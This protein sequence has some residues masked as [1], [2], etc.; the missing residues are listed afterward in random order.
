MQD[1]SH[2]LKGG[3][4]LALLYGLDRH[5]VDL[6]F[7]GAGA[8]SESIETYVCG[9]FEDAQVEMISFRRD[10]DT[11]KGQRYK[12]HYLNPE[13]HQDCLLKVELS[14]RTPPRSG[15]VHIVAGIR[16]YSLRALF[17]QK[18]RAANN[19]TKARDLF[20]LG[21]L[22]ETYG[23]E[24]STEQILRADDF[25]RDYERVADWYRLAFHE[26]RY[27]K[28]L[29][30]ADDRA[31]VLRIAVVEQLGRR[32]HSVQ[33]QAV[34]GDSAL[35]DMLASHRNWLESDGQKGSR[36]D[37]SDRSF[38][39][40]VLCNVN[41]ERAYL[42]RVN[43]SGADLRNANLRD[44]DL[45]DANMESTDLRGTDLSGAD[46]T[47]ASLDKCTLGPSTKGFVEAITDVVR[48]DRSRY[49]HHH[50]VS[51]QGEP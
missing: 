38:A 17:D 21:F 7:D 42:R 24:F 13:D 44:T 31:L 51:R 3:T 14:F 48:P 11:W 16:T 15:D 34:R 8:E 43:L 40:S 30:T 50:P 5:S 12:A 46:L 18:L 35:P 47:G 41:F 29:T 22:A 25:S 32:G 20:D 26:D 37:L 28:D 19:R 27:L 4:A 39:G 2:V 6:D 1:T 33:E 10:Y 36:A 45:R 49:I 9:G 23:D